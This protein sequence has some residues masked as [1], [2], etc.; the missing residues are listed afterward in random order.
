MHILQ[1]D[2][3]DWGLYNLVPFPLTHMHKLETFSV[4]SVVLYLTTDSKSILRSRY[5]REPLIWP[6]I[7]CQQHTQLILF[8]NAI[9][10]PRLHLFS[11]SYTPSYLPQNSASFSFT[12]SEKW[13]KKLAETVCCH[14]CH[15]RQEVAWAEITIPEVW[16]V[17]IGLLHD[18]ALGIYQQ[19]KFLVAS[20][21]DSA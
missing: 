6:Y 10:Q 4:S 15:F 1:K 18:T 5:R 2:H 20:Q 12:I 17:A 3:P 19:Q 7:K 14:G 8:T 16:T 21:L 13:K 11:F 9:L